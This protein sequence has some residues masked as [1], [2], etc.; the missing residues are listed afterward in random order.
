MQPLRSWGKLKK[1]LAEMC[2]YA[3]Y[4]VYFLKRA[5]LAFGISF[6][7]IIVIRH[8]KRMIILLYGSDSYRRQ[9]KLSEIVAEYR[10]KH[11]SLSVESFDLAEQDV[12][13]KLRDFVQAQSLFDTWKFG[14]I[15]QPSALS[16]AAQKKCAEILK[17]NRDTKEPVL[18]VIEDKKPAAPF[19]FL[20]KAPAHAQEFKELKGP[21]FAELLQKEAALRTI[22]FDKESAALF[23]E[24]FTGNS[25]G[26][27][28]ELDK[29]SLLDEKIITKDIL[30]IH[31]HA[32]LKLNLFESIREFNMTRGLGKRLAILEELLSTAGELAAAFN[33]AAA[34]AH[35]PADKEK[36]AAYDAAVKSGKLEY[37]EALTGLA[38]RS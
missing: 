32:T 30:R 21:A 13:E 7:I 20:L 25:W 5:K 31:L 38:L 15:R 18:V 8:S 14:V 22:R 34:F 26:M 16:G 24:A 28:T 11:S 29:L 23:V 33:M 35:S 9:Q 6:V 1:V 37:D 3:L 36:A 19:T 17:T 2:K 10:K 4:C 12:F 27:A